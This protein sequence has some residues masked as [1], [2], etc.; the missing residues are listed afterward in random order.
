MFNL[1]NVTNK[2]DKVQIKQIKDS[3]KLIVKLF[4][5]FTTRIFTHFRGINLLKNRIISFTFDLLTNK[6]KE[7]KTEKPFFY[8]LY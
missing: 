4:L 7:I 5:S 6:Y 1:I 3:E 2:I 8:L